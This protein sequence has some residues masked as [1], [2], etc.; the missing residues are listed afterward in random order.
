MPGWLTV[1]PAAV[2]FIISHHNIQRGVPLYA[3]AI[4]FEAR[5]QLHPLTLYYISAMGA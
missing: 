1:L 4:G 2:F 5:K 3:E